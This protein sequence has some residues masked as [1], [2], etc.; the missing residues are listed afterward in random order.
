MKDEETSFEAGD[1]PE[2]AAAAIT[3]VSNASRTYASSLYVG[4]MGA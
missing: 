1:V 3:M 4:G 2:S